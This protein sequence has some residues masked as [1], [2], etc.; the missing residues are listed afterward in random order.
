LRAG[1][2]SADGSSSVLGDAV[3]KDRAAV[4]LFR[5]R[6]SSVAG[7]AVRCEASSI[8]TSRDSE[9]ARGHGATQ[10]NAS[11]RA[12][13]AEHA[14][15]IHHARSYDARL[16][17]S[18]ER[19]TSVPNTQLQPTPPRPGPSR[20]HECFHTRALAPHAGHDIGIDSKIDRGRIGPIA[21]RFQNQAGRVRP[22]AERFQNQAGKGPTHR[23]AI[24]NQAGRVRPIAERF[25][26]QAGKGPTHRRAISK[27]TGK[28]GSKRDRFQNRSAMALSFHDRLQSRSR[29]VRPIGVGLFSGAR[30]F[31]QEGGR[32]C[33]SSNA[34]W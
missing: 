31:S 5:D 24:S 13:S 29:W 9:C 19:A 3:R 26:N 15:C 8:S 17:V 11:M 23:R 2:Q 6:S 1:R 25:Q 33:S 12:R 14:K 18:Y 34:A 20:S 28:C 22:I 10:E 16:G 4:T 7:D 30:L 27:S 32:D 21:E